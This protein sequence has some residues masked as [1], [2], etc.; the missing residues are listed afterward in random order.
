M[1]YIE[2]DS[3]I[4]IAGCNRKNDILP[5]STIADHELQSQNGNLERARKFGALMADK[6]Y[7]YANSAPD[8]SLH[9]NEQI[10]FVFASTV[11]F[12]NF[13]PSRITAVTALSAFYE[14][15]KGIS[16]DFYHV[17]ANSADFSFYYLCLRNRANLGQSVGETF[18]MIC[19]GNG[20]KNLVLR[21]S[22][23]FSDFLDAA[24]HIAEG[25]EFIQ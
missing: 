24:R 25:L 4:K 23:L 9:L 21:G 18:S 10:L 12:E 8:I 1:P 16:A 20:S 17:I 7:S 11:A 5:D 2:D 19:D 22:T 3:D 13:T 6:V 15:L 14:R